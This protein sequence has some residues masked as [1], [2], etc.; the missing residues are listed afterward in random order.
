MIL[1]V[2]F[3]IARTMSGV[4]VNN[5]IVYFDLTGAAQGYMNSFISMGTTAAVLSTFVLR[6]K[7]KKTTILICSALL[8]VAMMVLTG[9]S[10]SFF[11]LLAV[12][13]VY[14]VSLGWCD[15]YTNSC[16]VDIDRGSSA[17]R[18]SH[19]QGWYAV[20]AIIAPLA[21]AALLLKQSWQGVYII[22]APVYLLTIVNLLFSLKAAAREDFIKGMESPKFTGKEIKT[23]L[24]EKRSGLLIAANM[25]YYTMQYG[26]FAWLVRYMSVE[27]GV[28]RLGMMS[29]TV[30]W[31]CTAIAR[32]AAPRLP[33]DNMKLHA[34]GSLIAGLTLFGGVVSGNPLIM[35]L[36]I[37]IGALTT[38]NSLPALINRRIVTYK[39]NSL[40][41]SSAMFLSMQITGMIVPPAL[42]AISVLSMQGTMYV[43]A[44]A[45]IVSGVLGFAYLRLPKETDRA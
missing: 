39:G 35:C 20:G 7:Y 19:S 8:T 24:L 9:L 6:W 10:V 21:I 30:M 42:G 23:F 4:L 29:I 31:V 3:A 37:G 44:A 12:S 15:T 40:L 11:M 1:I 17:K 22:L 2:G 13:L 41:P 5:V 36:V 33:V 16:V 34:F 18:M 43:L 25:T 45:V 38:G 28:E 14:G 32:F 27:Y 26:L